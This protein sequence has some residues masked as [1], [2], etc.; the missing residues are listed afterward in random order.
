MASEFKL[1]HTQ[2]DPAQVIDCVNSAL[3]RCQHLRLIAELFEGNFGIKKEF[4]SGLDS[5]L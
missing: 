1:T 3:F 4:T 5:D 2:W